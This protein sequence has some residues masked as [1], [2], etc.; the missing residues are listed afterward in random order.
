MVWGVE[1]WVALL[2][3]HH[4]PSCAMVAAFVTSNIFWLYF[5]YFVHTQDGTDLMAVVPVT[6]SAGM[7][8]W[9]DWTISDV[10]NDVIVILF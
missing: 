6:E 4:L 9:T 2:L 3:V 7:G 1:G 5:G 8:D 10:I